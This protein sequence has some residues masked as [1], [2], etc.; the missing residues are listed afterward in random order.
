MGLERERRWCVVGEDVVPVRCE[1][2]AGVEW[3]AVGR[4]EA[5]V[6]LGRGAV[7]RPVRS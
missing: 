7:R 2:D 6:S 3:E 5:K 4:C 1:H